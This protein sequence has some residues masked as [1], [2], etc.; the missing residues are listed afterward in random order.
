MSKDKNKLLLQSYSGALQS[1]Y[2]DQKN[3]VNNYFK[4]TGYDNEGNWY[5]VNGADYWAEEVQKTSQKVS[6]LKSVVED[7]K[8]KVAEDDK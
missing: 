7:L 1:A 2:D 5:A 3:A 8:K 4:A 6:S